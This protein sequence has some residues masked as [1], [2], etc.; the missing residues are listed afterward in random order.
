MDPMKKC[1]LIWINEAGREVCKSSH[2][3]EALAQAYRDRLL[4]VDA[5][6]PV[7]QRMRY[8]VRPA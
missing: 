2:K 8:E 5:K 3:T 6:L 4:K 7:N 1:E